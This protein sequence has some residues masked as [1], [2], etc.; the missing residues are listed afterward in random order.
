MQKIAITSTM[1]FLGWWSNLIQ[2]S[3][4]FMEQCQT[5]PAD[6]SQACPT[7][8]IF[9]VTRHKSG[10]AM[11]S[12]SGKKIVANRQSLRETV[13]K[14]SKSFPITQSGRFGQKGNGRARIISS[15]DPDSTSRSFFKLL[16]GS[17]DMP[18]T[19]FQ[20]L[21]NGRVV[22]R[23]DVLLHDGSRLT[24]RSSTLDGSP[25]VSIKNNDPTNAKVAKYQNIHFIKGN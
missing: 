11:G 24:W 25:A 23:S 18:K 17:K 22:E 16:S 1:E 5:K 9:P 8:G 21:A 2:A 6:F 3:W 4:S 19:Y 14:T 10:I 20:K 7:Y 12:S 13:P 15:S